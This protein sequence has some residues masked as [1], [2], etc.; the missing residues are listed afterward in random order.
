MPTVRRY[1]AA[2]AAEILP[3]RQPSAVDPYKD[4]LIRR[5]NEGARDARALAAEITR[6]GY[7]G[8]D[9]QVR[10]YLRPLRHLPGSAPP[11]P[12]PLP[13]AR[14]IARWI[15]TSPA[16]LTPEDTAALAAVT[17]AIPRIALITGLARSFAD[18]SAGLTATRISP[19]TRTETLDTW[20]HAAE[21]AG[22]PALA[23]FAAG[24]R[25]D[26]DAVRNG[27]SLPWNSG[28]VEGTVSKIKKIKRQAYGRASFPL[29]R[30]LILAANQPT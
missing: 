30:K 18:I 3:A 20:L 25:Q 22:I 11:P 9:Q 23:S 7:Q 29:L 4:H 8:S 5:W 19:A 27:L 16:N 10:R 13:A 26:Y 1:A 28:K 12:P 15:M 6:L 21:T 2:T 24:I 17:A 14:D